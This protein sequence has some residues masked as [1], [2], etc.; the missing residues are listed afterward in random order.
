MS[1]QGQVLT[2]PY[3][4]ARAQSK[5]IW[6][7]G[8]G[9]NE[10]TLLRQARKFDAAALAS[11][12]DTYYPAIYRYILYRLGD[13]IAAEDLAAETFLRF[14]D[15][16][17]NGKG[18]RKTLR[19]WLFGVANNLTNQQLRQYAK[20]PQVELT[21]HIPA[22][23]NLSQ[24]VEDQLEMSKVQTALQKLTPEQAH[25]LSLRF[26]A[27]YSIAEAAQIMGKTEGA[28]KALQ[29]RAVE[30]LRRHLGL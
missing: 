9:M 2:Y 29:F 18:P 23:D 16:L 24:L 12:H 5:K 22:E 3:R 13:P 27:G 19:G 8:Q 1:V 15:A 28:V 14:L 10:G 7:D 11:I 4:R 25:I 20:K 26:S 6:Y 21:D 17:K 30:A